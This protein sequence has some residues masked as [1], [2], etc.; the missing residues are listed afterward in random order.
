LIKVFERRDRVRDH[1]SQHWQPDR[2]GW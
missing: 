2:V 1:L